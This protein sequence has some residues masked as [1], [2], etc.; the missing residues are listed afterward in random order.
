M[1]RKAGI[2]CVI[3]FT[4]A[5]GCPQGSGSDIIAPSFFTVSSFMVS[6]PAAPFE[7]CVC[8]CVLAGLGGSAFFASLI[9]HCWIKSSS[10]FSFQK[11]KYHSQ[12]LPRLFRGI[13]TWNR[14]V[15]AKRQVKIIPDSWQGCFMMTSNISAQKNVHLFTPDGNVYILFAEKSHLILKY[16]WKLLREDWKSL[17]ALSAL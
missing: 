10:F 5:E 17:S 9:C 11:F 1:R 6:S 7:L 16:C 2:K 4:Q 3:G 12:C 8:V 13:L 14:A 15:A